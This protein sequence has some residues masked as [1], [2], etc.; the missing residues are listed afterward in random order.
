[1]NEPE[2]WDALY[3]T[4]TGLE[5]ARIPAP[6]HRAPDTVDYQP[7]NDYADQVKPWSPVMGRT[8]QH[9]YD[10]PVMHPSEVFAGSLERW[11]RGNEGVYTMVPVDDPDD[12]EPVGWMLLH[13]PLDDGL[14]R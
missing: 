4:G 13:R 9:G 8:G 14:T 10:G 5:L 1:M 6:L 7:D 12:G 2:F 11:C 3:S